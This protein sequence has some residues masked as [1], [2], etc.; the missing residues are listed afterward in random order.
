MPAFFPSQDSGNDT[1]IFKTGKDQVMSLISPEM[2]RSIQTETKKHAYHSGSQN[3]K[4]VQNTDI[5]IASSYEAQD[6]GPNQ[7]VKP[8]DF[9]KPDHDRMKDAL[10]KYS[11]FRNEEE[12]IVDIKTENEFYTEVFS[13]GS[14][15][16]GQLGLGVELTSDQTY[17][18]P[19]FCSYNITIRQVSCGLNHAG[20]ITC[21]CLQ[22]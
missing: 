22:N 9:D 7:P 6:Y 10:A 17:T 2:M 15:R 16:N 13:W 21:K 12:L 8:T 4:Q 1:A 20:F 11:P 18:I 3:G 5:Q 19:R 14:D